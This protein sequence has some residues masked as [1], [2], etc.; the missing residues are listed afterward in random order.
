[1]PYSDYY[2]NWVFFD[3]LYRTRGQVDALQ[4]QVANLDG[5]LNQIRWA[6]SALVAVGVGLLLGWGALELANA[7][8]SSPEIH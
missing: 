1:M 8:K 2:N 6:T 3:T 7:R 5:K 4:R